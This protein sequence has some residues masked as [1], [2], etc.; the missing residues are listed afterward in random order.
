MDY[1]TADLHLGSSNIIKYC[2]RPF[3]NVGLQTERLINSINE[4]C[5]KN[6]T[7]YHLGD[8]VLYGRERGVESVRIKPDIYEKL[9]QCKVI[10]TVGNHDLNNQLKCHITAITMNLG[11][12][13][14]VLQHYPPWHKDAFT[15]PDTDVYLCGHIHTQFKVRVWEGK[16]VINVGCDVWN[17]RP[18]AKSELM[19]VIQK[20][21]S[22]ME[23]KNGLE[24][25]KRVQN[26]EGKSNTKR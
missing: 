25:N 3:K 23:R 15:H 1:F 16:V 9:I 19:T 18:I 5:N 22:K 8:F 12:Y 24:K 4:R 26:M 21:F 10:H 11:R 17:Y 14:A 2:K 13:K 7:L 6:D 20:E